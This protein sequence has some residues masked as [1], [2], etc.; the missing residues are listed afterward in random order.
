[1]MK[2]HIKSCEIDIESVKI[3]DNFDN[4]ARTQ[5]NEEVLQTFIEVTKNLSW[6]SI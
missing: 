3:N 6:E 4:S 2:I 5:I 1:M